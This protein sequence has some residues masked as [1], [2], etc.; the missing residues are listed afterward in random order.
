[1]LDTSVSFL[2][3]PSILIFKPL[4]TN[5]PDFNPYL[6]YHLLSSIQPII[7]PSRYNDTPIPITSQPTTTTTS[8][9]KPISSHPRRLNRKTPNPPNSTQLNLNS[10]S[11]S[12]P[13]GSH[14][15]VSLL[16]TRKYLPVVIDN[17]HNAFPQAIRACEEIALEALP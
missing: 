9:S 15:V 6:S 3:I 13:I 12:T 14:V 10:T 2:L 8:T 7:T 17:Y 1:M 4:Q 16:L 11:T 5:L